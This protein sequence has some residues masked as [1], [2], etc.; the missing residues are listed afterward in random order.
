MGDLDHGHEVLGDPA[1][2]PVDWSR[3][4]LQDRLS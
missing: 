2:E 1:Y 4:V 3:L